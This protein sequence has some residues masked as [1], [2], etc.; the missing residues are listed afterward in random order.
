MVNKNEKDL[1]TMRKVYYKYMDESERTVSV[2]RIV[3]FAKG[4][5]YTVDTKGNMTTTEHNMTLPLRRR[6]SEVKRRY[7]AYCEEHNYDGFKVISIEYK[8]LTSN[9]PLATF[10]ENLDYDS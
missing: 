5:V 8:K 10:M 3:T 4:Y 9:V 1:I 6:E 7:S 2:R